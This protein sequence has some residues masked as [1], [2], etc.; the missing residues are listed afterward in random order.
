MVRDAIC[1]ILG[2]LAMYIFMLFH[3]PKTAVRSL[4]YSRQEQRTAVKPSPT[5]QNS[6]K[7]LNAA[8]QY[9]M[10]QVFGKDIRTAMAVAHATSGFDCKFDDGNGGVGLFGINSNT[11][12]FSGADS[13]DCINNIDA[14][15]TVFETQ[16]WAGFSH[17]V[18][19]SYKKYL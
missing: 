11:Y 17:Y 3:L 2:L 5:P 12:P 14:A 16:G 19:G 6:T 1:F 9:Y 10:V 13:K 7:S 15:H 8:N 18:D 4:G